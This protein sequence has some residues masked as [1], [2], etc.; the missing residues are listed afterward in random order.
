MQE[1]LM[2]IV[3]RLAGRILAAAIGALLAAL[4][5]AGVLDAGDVC[6]VAGVLLGS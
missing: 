3:G 6:R 4:V 2:V 1:W 5:A